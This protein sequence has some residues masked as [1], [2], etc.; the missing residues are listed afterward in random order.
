MTVYTKRTGY[1]APLGM[2]QPLVAHAD[3]QGIAPGTVQ[4]MFDSVAGTSAEFVWLQSPAAI[5]VGDEV[6]FTTA[7]VAT[8]VGA[9]TGMAKAVVISGA[10]QYAWFQLNPNRAG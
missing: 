4:N 2:P 7:G 5:I 1:N 6:D 10:G 9:G 3:A 8:E